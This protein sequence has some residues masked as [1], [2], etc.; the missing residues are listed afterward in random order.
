MAGL[1]AVALVAYLADVGLD[2]AD[3]VGSVLGMFAALAAL[4][5]PYLLPGPPS[6]QPHSSVG[7]EPV[8]TQPGDLV[9]ASPEVDLRGA[10]GVQ[11][12]QASGNTQIN[13]FRSR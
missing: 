3:K 11:V 10:K 4:V 6:A 5:G 9:P 1:I 13:D 8:H 7:G 2:T 12:N